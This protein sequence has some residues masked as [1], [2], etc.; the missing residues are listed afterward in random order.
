MDDVLLVAGLGCL[1]YAAF[2]Q[3]RLLG[4]VALGVA[5]VLLSVA[6]KDVKIPRPRLKLGKRPWRS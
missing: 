3:D 6:A 2:L 1:V 4:F 5:L